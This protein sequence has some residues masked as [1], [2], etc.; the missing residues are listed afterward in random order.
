MTAPNFKFTGNHWQSITTGDSGREL[1]E[2][3]QHWSTS[4]GEN[5]MV[6]QFG[7][8]VSGSM[9]RWIYS[10]HDG[11]FGIVRMLVFDGFGPYCGFFCFNDHFEIP[12]FSVFPEVP[13]CLAA[14][15]SAISLH[16][17]PQTYINWHHQRFQIPN[18]DIQWLMF[19]FWMIYLVAR[20]HT[21]YC[22]KSVI[23]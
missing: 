12:C 11:F 2:C 3:A 21:N 16:S 23:Q 18:I 6:T 4:L 13:V 9:G 15:F 22:Y 20:L 19:S 1:P 5:L 14:W 10:Q 7:L 17:D 8:N